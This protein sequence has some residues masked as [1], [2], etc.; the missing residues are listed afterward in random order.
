MALHFSLRHLAAAAALASAC[1]AGTSWG[2]DAPARPIQNPHYGDSLFHFYQSHYFTSVTTLMVSQHFSRVAR[3]ADEAE[4]LRGGLLL[5]YGMH[6]EAGQIFAGLIE[7]NA[8]PAV[9]DRAWFYLAK[10][11]YQ[12]GFRPEAEE[13]I[14]RIGKNLPADLEEDRVLLKAQLEMARHDFGAAANTLDALARNNQAG[15]YA[16]YNLGV[17]LL[18]SGEFGR[19]TAV[20]DDIGKL[21]GTEAVATEE[22]RNLR[23][24]ANVAIGYAALQANRPDDA[25]TYLQRVRLNSMH[26][27]KALLGFGWAAATLKQPAQALVPWSELARR[28]ASDAA[29]LEARIAVPY[30]L[31]EMGA[32]GQSLDRYNDAVTAFELEGRQLDESA[33]AIRSGKLLSG[34]MARN[35]GDEMGWFWSIRELPEMPHATHLAQVLAQ[36]EF[37]EAFKNYRDL[38]F[39]SRNLNQWNESLATFGD[40]L[41]NRRAAYAERLPRIRQEQR[42]R[43]ASALVERR[44]ALVAELAAAQVSSDGRVFADAQQRA[45]LDRL[46]RV[47]AALDQSA[48]GTD[49]AQ[50][51]ERARRVA[52]ALTW[53]LAQQQPARQWETTKHLRAVDAGLTAA[54]QREVALDMA[55]KSEPARFEQLAVRIAALTPRIQALIPRVAALSNEQQGVVQELAVAELGRQ[56]ERLA[57][58]TVQARFAI[59]QLYDRAQTQV[60]MDKKEDHAAKP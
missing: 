28:D 25:R 40:M 43:G 52:G 29:V 27:N 22:N 34:L 15:L 19:G 38:Q 7:K 8:S 47:E 26:A 33:A 60:S 57:G 37:Q 31:A 41:A 46:G 18:R 51:R 36:H 54:A 45:L 6:R 1:C 12:R 53:A 48:A 4:V 2:A 20:L 23:D 21:K 30:A 16:R 42:N 59:A 58:Y 56:K 39:L 32:I 50:A 24:K 14:A 17:A 5:S 11:R 3:H 35:P 13:A 49:L 10:I 9:Q 55:Q 44:N